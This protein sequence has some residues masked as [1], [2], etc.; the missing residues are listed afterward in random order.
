MKCP[1]CGIDNFNNSLQCVRCGY[2]FINSTSSNAA[3]S[4]PT[5]AT[6][7]EPPLAAGST[8]TPKAV[9]APGSA[10]PNNY[11][12]TIDKIRSSYEN[13]IVSETINTDGSIT[14]Y[15]TDG[16]T[17][18]YTADG[19]II[20][21]TYTTGAKDIYRNGVITSSLRS[22]G[23]I[24]IKYESDKNGGYIAFD[25]NDK[26]LF[27]VYDSGTVSCKYGGGKKDFVSH[28]GEY[29]YDIESGQLTIYDDDGK[30]IIENGN[31]TRYDSN[32]VIID[33]TYANGAKDVY[34]NGVITSSFRSDGS[35]AVKYNYDSKGGYTAF[36]ENNKEL[37]H[38]Y[39]SGKIS[40]K[41]DNGAN[42]YVS[43]V[44]DGCSFD[45]E[46]GQL[47]IY[48]KDG[49]FIILD[50]LNADNPKDL[51]ENGIPTNSLR[52]DG[53]IAVKYQ[54]DSNGGYIVYDADDNELFHVSQSG[55]IT[56]NG[57]NE[58]IIS[59]G[60]WHYNIENN[61]LTIHK[62][63][64]LYIVEDGKLCK[65]IDNYFHD[66]YFYDKDENVYLIEESNGDKN[67]VN[68]SI[69]LHS[70][71][72]FENS[73][74]HERGSYIYDNDGSIECIF[75]SGDKYTYDSKGGLLLKED[76][77]GNKYDYRKMS[78]VHVQNGESYA[79][80]MNHIE[81]DEEK[82]NN[83]LKSLVQTYD[84]YSAD[85]D[86]IFNDVGDTINSFSEKYPI[87]AVT[88]INKKVNEDIK[89]L[90]SLKENINYSLLAYQA[91]D[92]SLK[93][94]L[95]GLIDALFEGE[96]SNAVK[97]F[98]SIIEQHVEDRNNDNIIEY[99]LDTDFSKL[100]K[101]LPVQ[102][103]VDDNGNIMFFNENGQLVSLDGKDVEI[104][105]GGETFI[106]NNGSNG[107]IIIRDTEG[108]ALNIFG[109]YNLESCQYGG[110]QMDLREHAL[111]LIDDENID[112]L[113]D[114]YFPGAT[115][116][117]KVAYLDEMCSKGCGY[118]EMGNVAFKLMEGCEEEF[119]DEFGYP[120]Y[121]LVL[122]DGNVSIDYNYEVL[123]ME[124]FSEIWGKNE[125]GEA[126]TIEQATKAGDGTV[127]S[128][129]D[130][131][132][133]YLCEE[134][135][136]ADY[137]DSSVIY[138]ADMGW[139]LFPPDTDEIGELSRT[140]GPHGMCITEIDE[141][142]RV[143]VSSWGKKYLYIKSDNDEYY[144]LYTTTYISSKKED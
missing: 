89:L 101:K 59:D 73:E 49:K 7:S 122:K 84:E 58:R 124:L 64:L 86:S 35:L 57:V 42:D 114:K 102:Q 10:P 15:D 68:A 44:N 36:D 4:A 85:I 66:V 72:S 29:K 24:A 79:Y 121:N 67:Y 97:N 14:I 40:C 99:K 96:D 74:T 61:Q 9:P 75:E 23:S 103:V 77:L 78:E 37:F 46:T 112:R 32:N 39:D 47:T 33:K 70:D 105:Y 87:D 45:V 55:L 88:K 52:S 125:N 136:I 137:T 93:D 110:N 1:I 81:Y 132:Y 104:Q 109:E 43:R 3:G 65:M 38:V 143:Y 31:A 100:S 30:F 34:E 92:N 127:P 134:Y 83:I 138:M 142:G 131:M 91:C 53:S 28:R 129:R 144:D 25:E 5:P 130:A 128:R 20:D 113:F 135:H 95:N 16:N 106:A 41:Y 27:H 48:E 141:D 51:F 90:D 94:N 76:S 133:N 13:G 123:T 69:I 126:V 21:R 118:V 60:E 63:D 108:N 80:R 8:P 56:Y 18:R 139:D 22:D 107:A 12:A 17:T 116:E 82:Y 6:V 111:D 71:G 117:E 140:G 115:P 2:N 119:L 98:K 26:E 50:T 54:L 11:I 120:M 62:D 19:I